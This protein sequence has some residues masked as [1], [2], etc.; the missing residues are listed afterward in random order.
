M[1]RYKISDIADLSGEDLS[2]LTRR[3]ALSYYRQARAYS[4]QRYKRAM[5]A[6]DKG[7]IYVKLKVRPLV[8]E[9]LKNASRQQIISKVRQYRDYLRTQQSTWEGTAVVKQKVIKAIEK[10]TDVKIPTKDYEKF[11]DIY[12]SLRKNYAEAGVTSKYELW[13]KIEQVMD[14]FPQFNTPE[15]VIDFIK[16]QIEPTMPPD[17]GDN[18]EEENEVDSFTISRNL[19]NS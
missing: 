4:E 6:V 19:F 3:Q 2:N 14:D 1:P 17:N 8:D 7:D 12:K 11:W 15:E 10:S 18:S 5:M 9:E 13:R 16:E